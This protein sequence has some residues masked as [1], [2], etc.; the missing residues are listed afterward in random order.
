VEGALKAGAIS[1]LLKTV[2]AEELASASGRQSRAVPPVAG[3]NPGAVQGIKE[4]KA[5][6]YDLT[7]AKRKSWH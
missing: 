6:E 3:S 1:Y 7:T 2:T 4:P 5:V